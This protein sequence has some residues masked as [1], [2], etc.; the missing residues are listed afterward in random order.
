MSFCFKDGFSEATL[1]HFY[2]IIMAS[3]ILEMT[4]I[5]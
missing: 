1:I 4:G 3:N 5:Q 2:T